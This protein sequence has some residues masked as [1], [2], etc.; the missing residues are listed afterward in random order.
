MRR[1]NW[2]QKNWDRLQIWG[3]ALMLALLL[4]IQF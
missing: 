4:S 3:V 1:K 2:L